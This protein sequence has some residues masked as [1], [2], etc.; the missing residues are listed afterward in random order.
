[1]AIYKP[2]RETWN[3]SFPPGPQEKPVLVI[4][5]REVDQRDLLPTKRIRQRYRD[6]HG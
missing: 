1:M 4:P 2:K 6:S 3:R 5:F